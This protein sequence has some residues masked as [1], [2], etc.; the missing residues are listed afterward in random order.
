MRKS[1]SDSATKYSVGYVMIGN[2]GNEWKIVKN[3]N[4]IKRWKLGKVN[5]VNEVNEIEDLRDV[6]P[7]VST[8]QLTSVIS[9]FTEEQL[10]VLNAVKAAIVKIRK[11]G[12][13]SD[14]VATKTRKGYMYWSDIPY[15]AFIKNKKYEKILNEDINKPWAIFTIYLLTDKG[16]VSLNPNSM[17]IKCDHSF[18]KNIYPKILEILNTQLN[19]YF[20]WNGTSSQAIMIYY[21]KQKIVNKIIKLPSIP[22]SNL[23]VTITF[24]T[25]DSLIDTGVKD[26]TE[27]KKIMKLI[28]NLDHEYSYSKYDIEF[29][30][31][32]LATLKK[33]EELAEKIE[34]ICKASDTIKFY[35]I[36][37]ENLI[38]H[39]MF[40]SIQSGRKPRG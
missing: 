14:I 13:L 6:G 8:R 31:Y 25:S 1:P 39:K 33:G 20:V 17:Y 4:G 12:V 10:Y 18:E 2:D 40:I 26:I 28:N 27:F 23:S 9:K 16:K 19:G 30:I 3:I 22:E 36:S 32:N 34:N 37:G 7:Y 21:T 24:N 29:Y 15:E 5:E 38:T 35:D 11:L